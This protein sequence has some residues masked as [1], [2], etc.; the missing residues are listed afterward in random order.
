MRSFCD[1][2]RGGKNSCVNSIPT[3]NATQLAQ[4]SAMT[5]AYG[6]GGSSVFSSRALSN[7]SGAYSTPL[8]TQSARESMP[9]DRKGMFLN[10]ATACSSGMAVKSSGTRLP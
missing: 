3:A 2:V 9:S 4:A 8:A 1:T 10:R 7:P 5:A 6:S